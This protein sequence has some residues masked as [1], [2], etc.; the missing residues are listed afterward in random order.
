MVWTVWAYLKWG[1]GEGPRL[2]VVEDDAGQ[3]GP[4]KVP[5]P[6]R[7]APSVRPEPAPPK[8]PTQPASW[9]RPPVDLSALAKVDPPSEVVYRVQSGGTLRN[10]ANLYKIYHHE[11][12]ALNPGIELDRELSPGTPVVVYRAQEDKSESV[13][14]PSHGSIEGAIP[15]RDGPGR[16]LKAIPWKRWGTAATVTIMDEVLRTW[17]ERF[18]DARPI[19]VGNLSAPR[20]GRLRP[21][22]THQSGR[23]VDLGYPQLPGTEDEYNWR[24]MSERNLDVPATWELLKILAETGAIEV[25]LMD[26]SLQKLLY[27]YAKVERNVSEAALG[28]WLEYPKRPGQAADALVQHVPGHIDHMH[29]RVACPP[30]QTR[31]RSKN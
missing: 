16:L 14:V 22:S 17:A 23:D 11:I 31:C 9:R 6:R 1:P 28:R 10:I 25:V 7:D 8:P 19:L 3:S 4:V 26:R 12:E 21:H 27:E 2:A 20:G 29:V 18:P 5:N 24:D 30:G 13:G 15:M